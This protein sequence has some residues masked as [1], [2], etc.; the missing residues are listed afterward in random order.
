MFFTKSKTS[1]SEREKE[2]RERKRLDGYILTTNVK[3]LLIYI[4]KTM[5]NSKKKKNLKKS[6][7]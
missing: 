1:H 4:F 6:F 2:V 3:L 7:I 5:E